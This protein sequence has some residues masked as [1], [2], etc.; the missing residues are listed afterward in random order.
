MDTS[1][2]YIT[3]THPKVVTSMLLLGI[4]LGI[5]LSALLH[6]LAGAWYMPVAF[7]GICTVTALLYGWWLDKQ[8]FRED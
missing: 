1:Q 5:V 4:G 6:F 3:F 7:V 8:D 2:L